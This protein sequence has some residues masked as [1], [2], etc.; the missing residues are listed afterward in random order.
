[1]A[2][3]E[4]RLTLIIE[5]LLLSSFLVINAVELETVRLGFVFGV[6]NAND[7][8]ACQGLTRCWSSLDYC[9]LVQLIL[10]ERPDTSDYANRHGD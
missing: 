6:W 5:D 3:V 2:A 9:V 7:G 1:M 10:Q 8:C 4:K